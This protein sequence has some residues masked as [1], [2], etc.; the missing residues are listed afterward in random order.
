MYTLARNSSLAAII[1]AQIRLH[2]TL[3]P[4]AQ[5]SSGAAAAPP[6]PPPAHAHTPPPQGG[7]RCHSGAHHSTHVV[8]V[9]AVL[10]VGQQVLHALAAAGRL[11][12]VAG[13]LGRVQVVQC[14]GQQP[15]AAPAEAGGRGR[16]V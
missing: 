7:L 1:H 11:A 12:H 15:R 14:L 8:V 6:P 10:V 5:R 9:V 13:D 2:R 4:S 3:F 16:R